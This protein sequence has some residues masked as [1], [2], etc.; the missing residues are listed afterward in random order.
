MSQDSRAKFTG[1]GISGLKTFDSV[2]VL[3]NTDEEESQ[4][5]QV[6]DQKDWKKV[7]DDIAVS[8]KMVQNLVQSSCKMGLSIEEPIVTEKYPEIKKTKEYQS[9][10]VPPLKKKIDQNDSLA[11][12]DMLA[13]EMTKEYQ[14]NFEKIKNKFKNTLKQ[15]LGVKEEQNVEPPKITSK[16]TK[17]ADKIT[18]DKIPPFKSPGSGSIKR[19]RHQ[20]VESSNRKSQKLKPMESVT[21]RLDSLESTNRNR[22]RLQ[23]LE[24]TDRSRRNKT[25]DKETPYEIEQTPGVDTNKQLIEKEAMKLFEAFKSLLEEKLH[26]QTS[27]PIVENPVPKNP[28]HRNSIPSDHI[29]ITDQ[30]YEVNYFSEKSHIIKILKRHNRKKI[31]IPK[32]LRLFLKVKWKMII[33]TQMTLLPLNLLIVEKN[34]PNPSHLIKKTKKRFPNLVKQ[35]QRKKENEIDHLKINRNIHCLKT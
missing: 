1:L 13:E 33:K 32:F 26:Q 7:I 16:E 4:Q 3:E 18:K 6:V 14:E 22:A 17:R 21:R 35:I 9:I 27:Q 23:P 31:K 12:V 25:A 5:Q 15:Q 29:V 19:D 11:I 20:S 24:S 8:Q 10:P 30:S 34:N 28:V 2:V